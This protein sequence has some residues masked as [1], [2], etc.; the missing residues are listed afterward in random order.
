M[1]RNAVAMIL[2]SSLDVKVKHIAGHRDMVTNS[3]SR[4]N[5]QLA[6]LKVPPLSVVYLSRLSHVDGGVK[7]KQLA[8]SRA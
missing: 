4:N 7:K 1:S 2:N 6:K 3:L 8:R 5:I